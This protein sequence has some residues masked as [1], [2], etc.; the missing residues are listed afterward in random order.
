MTFAIV[1]HKVQERIRGSNIA[2]FITRANGVPFEEGLAR[3]NVEDRIVTSNIRLT[4]ALVGSEEWRTIAD[5]F[6][7]WSATMI[8][9]AKPGK[10]LGKQIECID[11]KTKIKWVFTVPD[12]YRNERNA[13]LVA[14]HPDYTLEID[15]NNRIV[16]ASAVDIVS[17]F[18]IRD[19]WY[20]ADPIHG[21][22]TGEQVA[23]SEQARHLS[24]ID[25]KV[26]PVARGYDVLFGG[27][28][29]QNVVLGDEPSLCYGM[30][31]ESL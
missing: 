5:A 25:K 18:P 8:A 19:G 12:V 10:K 3:A 21:I 2:T 13:I 17:A 24:R 27:D 20:L 6:R 30:A 9:H 14:E 7:C 4:R 29:G 23:F 22:P 26:G 1:Q 31:V 11:S 16:H 28:V 15:G